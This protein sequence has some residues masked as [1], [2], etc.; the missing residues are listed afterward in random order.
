MKTFFIIFVIFIVIYVL[1]NITVLVILVNGTKIANW[2]NKKLNK[3]I[4]NL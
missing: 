3:K 2:Y 4:K 1:I